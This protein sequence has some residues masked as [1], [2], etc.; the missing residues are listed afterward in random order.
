[1]GSR[2]VMRNLS[3]RQTLAFFTG[4]RCGEH[5]ELLHMLST[6]LGLRVQPQGCSEFGWWVALQ[7]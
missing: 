2:A 4:A 7:G 3:I 6:G 1:M 5:Q